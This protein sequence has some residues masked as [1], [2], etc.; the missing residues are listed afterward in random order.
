MWFLVSLQVFYLQILLLVSAHDGNVSNPEYRQLP[1]L[2]EQA[3][4]ENAWKRE[5]IS[6]IPQ[7]LQKHG[8]DAWLVRFLPLFLCL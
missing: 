2:R 8:V 5:R 4:I 3:K 7:L 1:P 6:K